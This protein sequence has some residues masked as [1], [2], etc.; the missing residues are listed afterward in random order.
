MVQSYIILH[1][2]KTKRD[3]YIQKLLEK[4]RIASVDQIIPEG[5][6]GIAEVRLLLKEMSRK[7][8]VSPFKA[9]VI[10][11]EAI[12]FEAQ[13]ALLKTLEE[14]AA[15]NLFFLSAAH[16]SLLLPTIISRCTI[17]DLPVA[18]NELTGQNTEQLANFWQQFLTNKLGERFLT[19]TTVAA[20][21]EETLN[22]LTTQINF[23]TS[24]LRKAYTPTG[25]KLQSGRQLTLLLKILLN[26]RERI[27]RNGSLKLALDQICI[28]V[29][30]A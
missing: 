11:I 1:A 7:P 23:L 4:Y 8:F 5:T 30:F 10:E 2:Q 21:K 24:E 9:A 27:L 13:Q 26:V 17:V 16:K 12:S 22:W 20:T 29:P 28:Y 18:E 15:S 3:A 25:S 14:P 19:M 6:V